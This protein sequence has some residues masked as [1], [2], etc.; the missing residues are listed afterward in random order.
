MRFIREVP[1]G[2]LT[3]D[4]ILGLLAKGFL[5][6]YGLESGEIWVDCTPEAITG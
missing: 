5:L 6:L 4:L 1:L 3:S 2:N